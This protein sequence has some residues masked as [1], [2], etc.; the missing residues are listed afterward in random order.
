MDSV[1]TVATVSWPSFETDSTEVVSLFVGR[2]F[3]A[4]EKGERELIRLVG[5]CMK[6]FSL[7]VNDL[8]AW[9]ATCDRTSEPCDTELQNVADA[10]RNDVEHANLMAIKQKNEDGHPGSANIKVHFVSIK[11]NAIFGPKSTR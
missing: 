7:K 3:C 10:R 6:D 1:E 9:I 2:I 5:E 4:K 8:V 11:I